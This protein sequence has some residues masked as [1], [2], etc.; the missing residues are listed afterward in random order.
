[1]RQA[2]SELSKYTDT[3]YALHPD[4]ARQRVAHTLT[5]IEA[6]RLLPADT[7]LLEYAVLRAGKDKDKV[8]TVMAFV[9]TSDGKTTA[10]TLPV[11]A[12]QLG[13]NAPL[14]VMPA[15]TRISRFVRFP[16]SCTIA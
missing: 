3:L 11:K 15:P 14:S 5:T 8:D 13:N 10:H 12:E 1:M 4:L 7:A 9:V 2:E 6:A 16:G